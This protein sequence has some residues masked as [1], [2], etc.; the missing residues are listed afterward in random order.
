MKNV[1]IFVKFCNFYRRFIK[2]KFKLIKFLTRMIRKKMKF[3]W[4]NEIIKILIFRKFE[5]K[6]KVF[7]KCDFLNWYFFFFFF[8]IFTRFNTLW[9]SMR[10]AIY[11]RKSCVDA[12]FDFFIVLLSFFVVYYNCFQ[13]ENSM[14]LLLFSLFFFW[15]FCDLK[16]IQQSRWKYHAYC[17]RR[18]VD[19][20]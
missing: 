18:N 10:D 1:Q 13:C 17:R 4:S 9:E 15:H 2:K 5:C 3:E 14:S 6:K 20:F 16:L 7:F 11:W 19:E 12:T 8:L